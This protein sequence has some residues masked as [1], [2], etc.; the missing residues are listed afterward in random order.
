MVVTD[1]GIVIEARDEHSENAIAPITF[2]E[3]G[4]VMEV[5]VEDPLNAQ[6]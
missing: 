4:I 3:L 5:R 1:L 6:V 2:T